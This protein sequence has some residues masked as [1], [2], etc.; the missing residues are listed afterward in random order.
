MIFVF[1]TYR[2]CFLLDW[3]CVLFDVSLALVPV[4][5]YFG[6]NIAPVARTSFICKTQARVR[7]KRSLAFSH[8]HLDNPLF[9]ALECASVARKE[10]GHTAK[11]EVTESRRVLLLAGKSSSEAIDR[12]VASIQIAPS[13]LLASTVSGK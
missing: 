1:R 11:N 13:P 2:C 8:R 5:N 9:G 12:L 3:Y 6:W 10:E 7:T 4:A